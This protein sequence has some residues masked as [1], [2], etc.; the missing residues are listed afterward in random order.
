[1]YYLRSKAAYTAAKGLGIDTTQVE[2]T[3]QNTDEYQ[4]EIACSL[5]DPESCFSCGS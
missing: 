3:T 1:M 2:K 5:D 4:E